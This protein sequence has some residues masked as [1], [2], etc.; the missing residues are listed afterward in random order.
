[1]R[2]EDNEDNERTT[3]E[4]KMVEPANGR[5]MKLEFMRPKIFAGGRD[6][7]AHQWVTRFE[8]AVTF[9]GW[10]PADILACFPAYIDG[11]AYRWYICLGEVPTTWEDIKT[12]GNPD[13]PGLKTRFL[14][15]FQAEDYKTFLESKLVSRKQKE[16]ES[17]TEYYFQ[18]VQWCYDVEKKM[19]DRKILNYLFSGL[20]KDIKEFLYP[21]GP[22][23]PREFLELGKRIEEGRRNEKDEKGMKMETGVEKRT[24]E[25]TQLVAVTVNTNENGEMKEKSMEVIQKEYMIAVINGYKAG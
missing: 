21:M 24:T 13:A 9:N 7:D 25:K 1:M 2:N 4:P 10:G 8:K 20:R 17:I 15:Q 5:K 19:D 16:E 11:T 6:E 23:T 14:Q 3:N 22:K 18:K 12:E